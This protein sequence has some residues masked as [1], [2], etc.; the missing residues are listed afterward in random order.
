MFI[1]VLLYAALRKSKNYGIVPSHFKRRIRMS[2]NTVPKMK[3][4]GILGGMGPQ[5]TMDFEQRIHRVAQQLTP[6]DVNRGY[7]PMVVMYHRNAPMKLREDGEVLEPLEPDPNLL[8]LARQLGSVVDFLVI[9]CNTAH[10]FF[11]EIEEAAG[12]KVLSIVDI[13]IEEIVRRGV[14]KVG[15]L[16]VE[17]TLK[18]R[19][20]QDRLEARGISWETIPRGLMRRLDNAIYKLMEGG[21]PSKLSAP[22]H[23]AGHYLLVDKDVSHVLFACT[24]LPLFFKGDPFPRNMLNPNQLLAEAAVRYALEEI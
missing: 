17:E 3:T 12:R 2:E 19:L 23:Q 18:Y 14:S 24:E 1:S 21:D 20:Y 7:P 10:L 6:Q 8:E 13:T 15:L 9:P 16:A 4:I 5:A 22:A 11:H